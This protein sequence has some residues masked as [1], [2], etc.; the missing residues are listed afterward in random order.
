MD[1]I[2][3][4][5]IPTV[6]PEQQRALEGATVFV[7]G[8]GGLGGYIIEFLVRLG[9][10]AIT[11]CDGDSFSV[12]NLNRQILATADTLGKSK[13]LTA[14]DRA[15]S[16]N[17]GIRFTALETFLDESN[18]KQCIEGCDIVMDALDNGPSRQILSEAAS[19]LGLPLIHG[20]VGG[21]RLQAAVAGAD[22]PFLT[23][24]YSGYDDSAKKSVLSFVPAVCAAVQVAQAL[25]IITSQKA[26]LEDRF[27]M[28][29]LRTLKLDIIDLK[30]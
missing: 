13:V 21:F 10:G 22:N 7:A 20:A 18:A 9:I 4:R 2:F 5:N 12:S 23:S 29:D 25:E 27:L 14:R 24:L 28:G 16:I 1:D 15:L 17:P 30:R 8:C 3:E 6:T 19:Q 11:A 26:L